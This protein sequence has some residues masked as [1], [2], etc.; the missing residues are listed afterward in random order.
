MPNKSPDFLRLF[1][2]VDEGG[3]RDGQ[4]PAHQKGPSARAELLFMVR[5]FD[6]SFFFRQPCLASTHNHD[7]DTASISD[8]ICHTGK[9]M[10]SAA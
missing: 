4:L 5:N 6:A 7:R 1:C 3:E 8:K 9:Q 10:I 2:I